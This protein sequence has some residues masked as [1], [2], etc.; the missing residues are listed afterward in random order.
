M[1][2]EG[3]A[4]AYQHMLNWRDRRGLTTANSRAETEKLR[5]QMDKLYPAFMQEQHQTMMAEYMASMSEAINREESAAEPL[6]A[7]QE[8]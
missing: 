5:V 1:G 2:Y 3:I 8:V 4:K 6:K 7:A